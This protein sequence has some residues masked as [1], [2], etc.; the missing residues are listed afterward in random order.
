MFSTLKDIKAVKDSMKT[1]KNAFNNLLLQTSYGKESLESALKR[2]TEA[3]FMLV[4]ATKHG[5]AEDVG[6]AL[7][8]IKKAQKARM[9]IEGDP[10][11]EARREMAGLGELGS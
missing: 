8:Q 5:T 9:N 3:F 1:F 4:E 6:A 11:A 10:V 2:S 7:D